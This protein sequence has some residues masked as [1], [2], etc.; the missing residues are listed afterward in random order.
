MR[1]IVCFSDN[2][3]GVCISSEV[4]PKN[5]PKTSAL[6]TITGCCRLILGTEPTSQ[7]DNGR[8]RVVCIE[9]FMALNTTNTA[10]FII[11]YYLGAH[12][13]PA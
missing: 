2:K 3:R 1:D 5:I 12:L 7:S 10:A 6:A 9:V 8:C 4:G 11:G 13:M